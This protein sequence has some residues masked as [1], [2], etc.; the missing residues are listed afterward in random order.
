MS[1]YADNAATTKISDDAL[2]VMSF[3]LKHEYQ[4][5]SAIYN[6]SRN[7]KKEIDDC[8]TE[9]AQ[10]INANPDEIFFTSGGT[11]SNNWAIKG[12]VNAINKPSNI[13]TSKIEHPS[14]LNVC[15]Q[16]ENE[17]NTVTYLD[18]NSEGFVDANNLQKSI[19]ENTVL[20]SIMMANNEIGTIQPVREIGEICKKQNVIFHTDAVQAYTKIPI[21][22][23][24]MNINLMSVS[25]HKFNAPKGIGFLYIQNGIPIKNLIDGGGQEKGRRSG[26]ENFPS[27]M[28]MTCAARQAI[29]VMENRQIKLKEMQELLNSKMSQIPNVIITG[30]KEKRIDGLCSYCIEG[31]EGESLCLLLDTMGIMVSSG[32]ACSAGNL[33]PSHVLEAINIDKKL[34]RNSVRISLSTDNTIEEVKEIANCLNVA[35]KMIRQKL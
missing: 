24:A 30:S 15:K 20:A 6:S 12:V 14:V 10:T 11:E 4:N 1:I 16:I 13:I 2:K 35:I 33:R 9:I 31:V 32:S 28:A 17:T 34:L 29:S 19:Q 25:G 21:D 8:R 18:V 22:V 23:K 3:F 27:I 5:P 7:I 26:T